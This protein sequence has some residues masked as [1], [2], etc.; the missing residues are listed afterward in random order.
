MEGVREMTDYNDGKIHGWNGGDCPVHPNSEVVVWFRNQAHQYP[1]FAEYFWWKHSDSDG[2]IIAFQVT[3]PYA[4]P[5]TIWVNEYKEDD[6][7]H[8]FLTEERA[9]RYALRGVTRIAV[10]YVEAKE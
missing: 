4:E 8:S 2:D 5:K 3:K 10:K 9:K 6:A 1:T 7:G